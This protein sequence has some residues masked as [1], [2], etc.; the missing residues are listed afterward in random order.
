MKI[1]CHKIFLIMP[2]H[3]RKHYS[4]NQGYYL[5]EAKGCKVV[6]CPYCGSEVDTDSVLGA[7]LECEQCGTIFKAD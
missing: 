2:K 6:R 4:D 1:M 7:C 3:Y 5:S